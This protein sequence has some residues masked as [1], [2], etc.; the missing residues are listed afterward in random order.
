[1]LGVTYASTI[2]GFLDEIS[3][4]QRERDDALHHITAFVRRHP[5]YDNDADITE[6]R[7]ALLR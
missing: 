7:M 6:C 2:D 5:E 4:L 3:R 1:M